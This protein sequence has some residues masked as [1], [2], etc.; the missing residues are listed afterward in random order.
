[1]HGD[2]QGAV[3]FFAR[4]SA[5]EETAGIFGQEG[6]PDKGTAW[7]FGLGPRQCAALGG[8]GS[9]HL[10]LVPRRPQADTDRTHTTRGPLEDLMIRSVL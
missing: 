6:S 1:M 8:F 4:P 10:G 7:A 2:G 5:V 9:Q 3:L